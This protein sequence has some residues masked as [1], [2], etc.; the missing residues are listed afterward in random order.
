MAGDLGPAVSGLVAKDALEGFHADV[1]ELGDLPFPLG[2]EAAHE[3]HGPV[4]PKGHAQGLHQLTHDGEG[5]LVEVGVLVGVDVGGRLVHQPVERVELAQELIADGAL[6]TD[7]ELP[8][9]LAP[10]VPVEPDCEPGMVAAHGSRVARGPA[11]DHQ[12]GAGDDAAGV[13]VQDAAV[14]ALGG[15]EVV[16]VEDDGLA[17]GI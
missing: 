4:A 13:A 12:A 9:V 6:V 11:G 5:A 15:A 3:L 1:L 17:H 2:I 7:V 14:H 10:H 8:L 16:G